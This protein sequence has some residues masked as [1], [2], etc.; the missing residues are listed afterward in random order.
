MYDLVDVAREWLSM[1]PC[2]NLLVGINATVPAATLKTRVAELLELYADVDEMMRTEPGFLLGS[3]LKHSRA[4]ADWD[5][6]KGSLADFY[7]WNARTQI[8]SWA[9]HY[10]RRE[11]SGMVHGGKSEELPD[12][13]GYYSG[14]MKLWL[15]YTLAEAAPPADPKKQLPALKAALQTFDDTWSRRKWDESKLPSKPVGEPVAIAAKL[16]TKYSE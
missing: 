2:L 14:R 15:N 11:W 4:V 13:S 8:S 5:G 12:G 1:M 16:L 6:S 7:E 9:G 10:S 3:W